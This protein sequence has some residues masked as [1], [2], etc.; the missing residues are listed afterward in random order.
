MAD[1]QGN[2]FLMMENKVWEALARTRIPGQ[3][4]QVLDVII[5]KTRGFNKD[6]DAIAYSQF[7]AATGIDRKLIPR[8]INILLKMR[9]IHR[10]TDI[11]NDVRGITSYSFER[12]YDKWRVTS[13]MMLT[14]KKVKGDIKI[15]SILEVMMLFPF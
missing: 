10:F 14:S 13:N 11:K 5:R 4:R 15:R 2:G 7:T 8:A 12:D 9:L 1:P 3:A 6:R